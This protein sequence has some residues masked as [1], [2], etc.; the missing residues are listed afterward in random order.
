MITFAALPLTEECGIIE[1]VN[2]T[3]PLRGVLLSQYDEVGVRADMK[4]IKQIYINAKRIPRVH[5]DAIELAFYYRMLERFEPVLH[6]WFLS[7]FQEPTQWFESRL[8]FTRSTAVWSMVGYVLGL[9]DRHLENILLRTV[10][11]ECVH[12]DF[13]CLFNRGAA[14]EKPERVPFRLTQ[15]IV[16]GF[17]ITSYNG[18]FRRSCEVVL[19]TLRDNREMLMTAMHAFLHDPLANWCALGG[20]VHEAIRLVEQRL[21]GYVDLMHYSV[22]GQV[23][24]VIKEAVED[25][26]LSRMFLGWTPFW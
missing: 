12:V 25:R 24:A 26:N 19:K 20:N 11:G 4:T 22:E 16:D 5:E 18:V 23:D 13:D 21:N 3:M 1:W 17:G 15:N 6:R 2:D 7:R 9:G 10:D 8:R 14:L